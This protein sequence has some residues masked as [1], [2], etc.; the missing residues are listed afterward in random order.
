MLT[1]TGRGGV[2]RCGYQEAARLGTWKME[3]RDQQFRVSGTLDTVDDFWISQEPLM[4]ALPMGR[5]QWTWPSVIVNRE[6]AL[7]FSIV[8]LGPPQIER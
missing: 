8:V 6:G 3:P 2:V 4:L 7:G 5:T 1:M